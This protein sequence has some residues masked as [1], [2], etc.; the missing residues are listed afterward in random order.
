MLLS[1]DLALLYAVPAK[2]LVQ[3]VKRNKSRFPEDFMFQLN[4][5]E[6]KLGRFPPRPSP[7]AFTE[8]GVARLSS[9]LRSARAVQVHIAIMRAF[10]QLRAMLATHDDLRRKIGEMEKRYDA[11]F[12]TVFTTL[13]Q[14]LETPIPPKRQIAFHT[15]PGTPRAARSSSAPTPNH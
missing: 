14:R 5:D 15:G 13:W 4:S 3:A 8:H 7:Y 2:A 12:Q 9:V 10:V 6:M 11:R 1:S